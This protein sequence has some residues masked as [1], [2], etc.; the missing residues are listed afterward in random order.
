MFIIVSFAGAMGLYIERDHGI[1]SL[2]DP[3][4]RRTVTPIADFLEGWAATDPL[5]VLD[6]AS[7]CGAD[8]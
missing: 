5:Y 6:A 2:L 1:E 3:F 7:V 8:G 4:Y